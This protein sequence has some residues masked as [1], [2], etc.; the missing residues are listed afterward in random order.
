MRPELGA[1]VGEAMAAAERAARTL[2][3]RE[4]PG[5]LSTCPT[6]DAA[7]G[8]PCRDSRGRPRT[9]FHTGRLRRRH[10]ARLFA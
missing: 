2:A 9:S 3:E 8:S 4:Q 1:G 7:P 6:C 10:Q 5:L